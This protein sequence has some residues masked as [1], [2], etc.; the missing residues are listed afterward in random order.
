METMIHLDTNVLLWLASGALENLS[1]VAKQ[2][3]DQGGALG[4]SPMVRLELQYL[5]EVKRLQKSADQVLKHLQ[6]QMHLE[7]LDVELSNLI[8]AS[9]KLH[10][11]CDP[12][13]RLI[14]A[15]AMLEAVPLLTKDRVIR[16]HYKR[17]IW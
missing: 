5:H 14:T 2:H 4:V 15:H 7:F 12:F 13:D 16:Q 6:A 1:V 8:Q 17:A 3:I 11:T 9:L 10:W